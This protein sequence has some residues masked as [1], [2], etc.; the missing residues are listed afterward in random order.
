MPLLWAWRRVLLDLSLRISNL[1][2]LSSG[3][4]LGDDLQWDYLGL[5]GLRGGSSCLTRK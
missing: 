5:P 3:K 4:C 2:A 1:P